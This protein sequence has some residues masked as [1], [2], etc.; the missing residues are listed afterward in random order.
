MIQL[1]SF[2]ELLIMAAISSGPCLLNLEH[3]KRQN[4]G[5]QLIPTKSESALYQDISVICIVNFYTLK[6]WK[7]CSSP[8]F[9]NIDFKHNL[10]ILIASLRMT[11]WGINQCET[12]INNTVKISA[13]FET[14][15]I[16]FLSRCMCGQIQCIEK[17]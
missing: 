7:Y 3:R 9:L 2:A 5:S 4:F 13:P 15:I 12:N 11:V 16:I 6:F 8:L 1:W 10:Q 14:K 17:T